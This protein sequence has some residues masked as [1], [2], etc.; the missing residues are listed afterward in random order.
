MPANPPYIPT[1]DEGLAT[2]AINFDTLLTAAPA[3]YGLTAGDALIVAGLVS[4]YTAALTLASDPGTR[5]PAAV[6]AKDAARFSM[7]QRVRIFA[8]QI[9]KNPDVTEANKTAVGVP[10]P[11][12]TRSP[13]PPP[14]VPPTLAFVGATTNTATLRYQNPELPAGKKKGYGVIGVELTV[15]VTGS[16]VRTVT[17][18]KAPAV[19][20][21]DPSESGKS[22]TIVGRFVTRSGAGGIA[23]RGPDSAPLSFT[24]V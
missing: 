24:L 10:V 8:Q 3:T 15:T 11:N 2:W 5:T 1:T 22:C 20:T 9:S 21:F 14:A 7:L 12:T 18:T 13:I 23:Y 17:V 6:A 16:P 4:A 19:L